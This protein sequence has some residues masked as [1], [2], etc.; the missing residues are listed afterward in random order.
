MTS[1]VYI[2]EIA[3]ASIRGLCTCFFTGAVYIGIV[4]AYFTNYGSALHIHS[5]HN[6]WLVPTS[7]HIMMAGIILILMFFQHESPRFLVKQGKPEKAAQVLAYI[8]NQSPDSDYIVREVSIVQAALDHEMEATRG[9]GFFGKIKEMFLDKSNLYRVYL[10]FMVQLLSQ[11]SG[12]GSITLYAND[13][14]KI[15]GITGRNEGLLVTAVFG[16]VKMV[17]ALVCALFLVDVIGRKLSLLL[18]ITLQAIAMIYVASFLTSVPQLGVVD[19]FQVPDK[20]VAASRGAIA[21]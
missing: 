2:A 8:R 20:D 11:W 13:L 7:L 14:F 4:L 17:S 3:P 16:I 12:A 5:G 18:G 10:A 19:K 1:P 9:V 6:Q 15:I 21:M